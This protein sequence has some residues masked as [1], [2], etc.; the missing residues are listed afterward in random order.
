MVSLDTTKRITFIGGGNMASAIIGGLLSQSYPAKN[1]TV[2]EPL[3]AARKSLSQKFN[4]HTTSDNAAAISSG[5]AD[6]VILAVKPQIMRDVAA[7]ISS[8]VQ[9]HKS[10]VIT[11]AA[12]IRGSDL[13]AWLGG[14]GVAVVRVMPNTP[15][16]VGEGATGMFASK[17]VSEVQKKLAGGILGAVSKS[18]HWV[19]KEEL[20]DVVTALSG[21]GPAYF[22]LLVESLIS[23]STSLGLD[24]ATARSLAAQTC[25]GA[26]RMMLDS[27]D[28]PAELRRKVTSPNGTTEAAIKSFQADGF[29]GIVKKAVEAATRRGEELGEAL[30]K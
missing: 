23:A 1:I 12:G 19:E 27:E 8:A 21:S 15:A 16:L 14:E 9:T 30:S 26:G 7:S 5:P 2:S 24:P 11:I 3:E 6:V 4:V 20:M 10:L 18:T 29:E 25:L 28:E 13:Q 22:F 17:G